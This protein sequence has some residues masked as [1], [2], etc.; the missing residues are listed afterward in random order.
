MFN[1]PLPPLFLTIGVAA[2]AVLAGQLAASGSYAL[3][4]RVAA[5]ELFV[6]LLA[7]AIAARRPAE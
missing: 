3:S 4:L 1:V 5:L 7:G 6:I 2:P